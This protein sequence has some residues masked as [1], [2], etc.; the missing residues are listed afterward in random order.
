[1]NPLAWLGWWAGCES[2]ALSFPWIFG[3]I[4]FGKKNR[5]KN[6]LNINTKNYKS[7]FMFHIEY[8]RV[9]SKKP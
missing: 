1:M 2:Q 8:F 7:V 4:I 9:T 3:K 6:A 5:M